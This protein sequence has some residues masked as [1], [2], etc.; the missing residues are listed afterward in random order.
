MESEKLCKH[1]QFG[2]CKYKSA[3]RKIHVEA[4][5]EN[6]SCENDSCS[7]R[8]PKICKFFKFYGRCKFN[9][10]A[11][12]HPSETK[13]N[14][15]DLEKRIEAQESKSN[16]LQNSVIVKLEKELLEISVSFNK[17]SYSNSK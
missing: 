16:E 6:K 2:Y 5:C 14:I 4:I 13:L 10:C 17:I 3:C 11:Y 9:P 8:H 1:H 7:L 12:F 15:E